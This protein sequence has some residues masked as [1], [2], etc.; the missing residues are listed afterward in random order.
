MSGRWDDEEHKLDDEYDIHDSG[1][2]RTGSRRSGHDHDHDNDGDGN[3]GWTP[4]HHNLRPSDDNNGKIYTVSEAS[5]LHSGKD[6][7]VR[8]VISGVQPLRKMIKGV[9]VK[10]MGCNKIYERKYDMPEL[11]ESFVPIERIRKCVDCKTAEIKHN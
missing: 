8:G 7:S 11:F 1:R 6:I 9:S 10:C 5:R 2:D 4:K 3:E